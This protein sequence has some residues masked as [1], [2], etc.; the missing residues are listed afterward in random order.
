MLFNK[1]KLVTKEELDKII[2]SFKKD[3]KKVV[4]SAEAR[5][6]II[7]SVEASLKEIKENQEAL[8]NDNDKTKSNTGLVKVS[9]L[10]ITMV[11]AFA[12][13]LDASSI[14]KLVNLIISKI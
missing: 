13:K 1:N 3:L 8:K 2:S 9:V 7:K 12:D 5:D 6:E 11:L 10:I 4:K 14:V